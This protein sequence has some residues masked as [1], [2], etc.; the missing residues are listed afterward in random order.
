[1]QPEHLRD[2]RGKALLDVLH[3]LRILE[4]R[5]IRRLE[6][7]A[8]VGSRQQLRID[9]HRQVLVVHSPIPRVCDVAAVHD[10]AEDVPQIGPWHIGAQRLSIVQ[11]VPQHL[12][13]DGK[14]AIVEGVFLGPTLGTELDAAG[15][16][17][18]EKAQGEKCRLEL[19]RLQARVDALLG[20]LRVGAAEVGLQVRRG[21]IRD[22]DASLED[23]LRDEIP[24][25]ALHGAWG[26]RR[27]EAAEVVMRELLDHLQGA[28]Q[29]LQPCLH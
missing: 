15:D 24:E 8:E 19:L 20:E 12:T 7:C 29:L 27:Q 5:G 25:A 13:A 6:A 23:R 28:L 21:L 16:E 11:V 3:V 17:R 4:L 14:I 9:Q 10:L 2:L 1:M 18:V 26:F 22:L